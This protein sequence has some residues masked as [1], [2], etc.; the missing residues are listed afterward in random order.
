MA[1]TAQRT[2]F[3][4]DQR[5]ISLIHRGL[6]FG[7]TVGMQRLQEIISL[8]KSS[9]MEKITRNFAFVKLEILTVIH[10]WDRGSILNSSLLWETVPQKWLESH[11]VTG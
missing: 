1:F 7:Y 8:T 11:V 6:I 10:G 4:R 2:D 5:S 9:Y 3:D